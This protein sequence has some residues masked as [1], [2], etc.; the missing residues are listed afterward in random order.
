MNV[1]PRWM[2]PE[3]VSPNSDHSDQIR[4]PNSPFVAGALNPRDTV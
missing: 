2:V 3:A 1:E 4:C